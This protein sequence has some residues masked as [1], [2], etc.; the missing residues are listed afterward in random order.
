MNSFKPQFLLKEAVGLSRIDEMD[1]V[2]IKEVLQM[3]NGA[4][5]IESY[6]MRSAVC[7]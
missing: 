3:N 4:D 7:L 5:I 6:P 2:Q 1:D